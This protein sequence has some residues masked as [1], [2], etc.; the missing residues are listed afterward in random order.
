MT[1]RLLVLRNAAAGAVED[2]AVDTALGVLGRAADTVV[3]A[4]GSPEQLRRV[5][6]ARDG[7]RLVVLGG[8]GSLHVCVQALYARG[9]LRPD[10]PLALVPLGTGND[11]AR[12]LGLLLDPTQAAATVLSGRPRALDLLV[13]DDGNVVVNV[14]H[15]GVGAAAAQHASGLKGALGPAAYVVGSLLAGATERGWQL[16]VG[17]DGRVLAGGEEPVLMVGVGI[18]R[19]IGGG[20]PLAPDPLPDDGLADVVVSLSTG[21]LDRVGYAVALREGEHVDR[22][23][24]LTARGREVT[25]RG[26]DFPVNADGEL[27]GPYASRTWRVLPGA[28][29]MVTVSP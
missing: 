2:A 13:D 4:P 16:E 25:V 10:D 19:T 29:S 8:D 9:E 23:D 26:E 3:E 7:R 15:A 20:S 18:G 14:V 11:L 22:P 24:V 17:V 28:W 27:A 5:L 6:D 1:P 12:A 21:P